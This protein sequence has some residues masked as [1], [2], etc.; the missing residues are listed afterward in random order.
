M[1]DTLKSLLIASAE[2]RPDAV[3]FRYAGPEGWRTMTYGEFLDEVRAASELFV[4]LGMNRG[5]H[6]ALHLENDPLWA[7]LY[8]GLVSIGVT[9]VPVDPRFEAG[10]VAHLI[11]HGECR[12][13][14]TAAGSLPLVRE[15]APDLP[16]LDT[17]VLAGE[18]VK[19]DFAGTVKVVDFAS[20]SAALADRAYSSGS[21]FEQVHPDPDTPASIIFTSGT[22][23]RPK[24]AVLTHRNFVSNVEACLDVIGVR[25]DDVFLLVLPLHHVFAFTTDLLLP[26]RAGAGISLVRSIRTVADDLRELQPTALIAV[27]LLLEKLHDRIFRGIREQPLAHLAWRAGLKRAVGRKVRRK[28]GGRLRMVVS[29]GAPAPVY[30]LKNFMSLGIPILEGYGLTE[31]APVVSVNPPDDPRPGTAGTPLPGVEVEVRRPNREGIGELAVRGPGVMREYYRNPDD[32]AEV[33]EGGWFLTGDLAR[34]DE[35]GY[36]V[37]AGRRKNMIVNREGKNIYPEEVEEAI[38]RSPLILESL[39]LGIREEGAKGERV[40]AIVVPDREALDRREAAKGTTLDEEGIGSLVREEVARMTAE[41]SAYK[42]P[43]RVRVRA[44]EF[45]KTATRKIKRYLYDLP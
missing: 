20:G 2:R 31:T 37:I 11:R 25:D 5:D 45:E 33:M 7:V 29:G 16:G 27:P 35:D 24:G 42:R 28:L 3:L 26:I 41:L 43:R 1:S 38:N 30:M 13:L 12:T 39:V 19:E 15:I 34:I 44:G 23:G 21:A 4:S 17:V 32:T 10:E 6:V 18:R 40:G 14:I 36:V 9:A 8:F 22:T